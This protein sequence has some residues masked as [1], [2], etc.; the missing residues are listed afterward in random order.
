MSLD[1]SNIIRLRPIARTSALMVGLGTISVCTIATCA[2]A[3]RGLEDFMAVIL[4]FTACYTH[5]P[6][7]LGHFM[8]SS[9]RHFQNK[10][11]PTFD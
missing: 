2:L 9:T 6:T 8:G 7:V 5:V 10:Q 4:Q 1:G 3:K 11:T